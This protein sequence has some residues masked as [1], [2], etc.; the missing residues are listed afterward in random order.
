MSETVYLALDIGHKR[1]G[2]AAG[3]VMAFGRGWVSAE[4]LDQAFV[5]IRDLITTEGAT[6]LIV[7]IPEVKSGEITQ[8]HQQALDWIERLK[9]FGL[10]IQTVNE[11]YSSIEAERQ[12]QEEGVDIR[13]DKG[14]IDE[15]SAMIILEHHLREPA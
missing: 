14:R 5:Y 10:P 9:Q 15:R 4:D 8:S 2:L 12:L 3:S 13:E 7:G 1:I 11:A 6:A